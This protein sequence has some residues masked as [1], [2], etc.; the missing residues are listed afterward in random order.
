MTCLNLNLLNAEISKWIL[1]FVCVVAAANVQSISTANSFILEVKEICKTRGWVYCSNSYIKN[2]VTV[3]MV[4]I[5]RTI[6]MRAGCKV[7]L[8]TS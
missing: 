1:G 2:I 7:C 6:R 8:H 5:V 3:F 4:T